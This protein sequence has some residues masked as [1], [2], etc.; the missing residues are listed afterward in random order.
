MQ[1]KIKTPA[2]INLTLEILGKR[3]DGFHEIK[4]IMQMINLYDYLT[5]D[6]QENT[7]TE[8]NLSG[9]TD[10]IPY[11]EKNIVFKAIQ[12]FIKAANIGPHKYNVYIEK[13]IPTEAGLAGGSSN[14]VGTLLVF[15]QYFNNILNSDELSKICA[16]LGSDL[17]VILM[18]GCVLAE[19][20]GELVK[21]LP[22][23]EYPVSLIKPNLGISAKEGY[24][25]Y[26]ELKIKPNKN[27]TEK[28]IEL[29][30]LKKDIRK[31]ICNDLEEGVYNFYTELQNIKHANPNSIMTG[32]GSTYFVLEN[33]INRV[34]DYWFAENLKTIPNG[35]EI[36]NLY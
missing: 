28:V 14:A 3:T 23:V 30:K 17:N 11:N 16:T 32:S 25:K 33:K 27:Y 21:K 36:V 4:S 13:N 22:F 34:E 6:I 29:L 9:N 26:S 12:A 15:N 8:I 1:I 5:F 2:K 20:R 18:G 10:K 7:K 24:K 19:G 31:Y 35:C